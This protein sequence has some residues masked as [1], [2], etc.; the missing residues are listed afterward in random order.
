MG[1]WLSL[2]LN[3]KPVLQTE[4]V[5]Y[6]RRFHVGGRE[7]LMTWLYEIQYLE[8]RTS[9]FWILTHTTGQG[10]PGQVFYP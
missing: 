9:C 6:E 5:D 3:R 8:W 2:I 7:C 10:C 4:G 1:Q